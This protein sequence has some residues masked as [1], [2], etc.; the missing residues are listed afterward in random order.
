[1]HKSHIPAGLF[2]PGLFY[3]LFAAKSAI[4]H[5]ESDFFKFFVSQK[6][7]ILHY[8]VKTLV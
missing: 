5:F 3:A 6:R 4:Y 8:I 2:W 1:M 7:G